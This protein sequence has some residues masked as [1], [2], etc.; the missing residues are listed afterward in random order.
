[1]TIY[2]PEFWCGVLAVILAEIVAIVAVSLFRTIRKDYRDGKRK[3]NND[4]SNEQ[5]ER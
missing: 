2:I 5:S 4:K 3:N 1:M